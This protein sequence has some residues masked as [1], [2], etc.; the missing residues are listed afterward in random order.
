MSS[1]IIKCTDCVCD[2][3]LGW[4]EDDANGMADASWDGDDGLED[5]EDDEEDGWNHD[6]D[7]ADDEY[8]L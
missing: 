1:P 8:D 2:I 7:D 6:L 4:P 3:D 5:D